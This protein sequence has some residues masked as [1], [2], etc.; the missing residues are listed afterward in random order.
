MGGRPEPACQ[1][2]YRKH[3]FAADGTT[4]VEGGVR[5]IRM[6]RGRQH[7]RS[8]PARRLAERTFTE[9]RYGVSDMTVCARYA[10]RADALH[11]ARTNLAVLARTRR[12]LKVEGTLISARPDVPFSERL[13]GSGPGQRG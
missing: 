1:A 3:G 10:A 7:G 8:S 6:V 12:A 4:K 13:Y 11:A 9:N 5:E 2:F